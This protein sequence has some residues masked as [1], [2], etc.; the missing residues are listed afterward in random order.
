MK[1]FLTLKILDRFQF[2]FKKLKVDYPTLR[3]IL[4]IKFIMDSRRVPVSVGRTKKQADKDFFHIS[5]LIYAFMGFFTMVPLAIVLNNK[6]ALMT[7]IFGLIMF[8]LLM[9]V[10]ADFSSVLLDVRDKSII[11]TKPVNP[12]VLTV[13]KFIHVFRYLFLVTISLV[14]PVMVTLLIKYTYLEGILYALLFVLLFIFEVVLLNLFI[15]VFTTLLYLFILRFFSGE[16]LKDIINYIQIFMTLVISIGYQIIGR[17]FEITEIFDIEF[18]SKWY[19]YLLMPF[20]F[21]GPFELFFEANY[22]ISI[23][24]YTILIIIIP[25]T[26]F[27]IYTKSLGTF[28]NSLLKLNQG[29][30]QK[31]YKE[32]RKF[33]TNII[34]KTPE[35][36]NF[37][38]FS[39]QMLKSERDFKLRVYP[40]LGL[41]MVFPFLFMFQSGFDLTKLA[42]SK[43]YLN[44]YFCAFMMPM[45]TYMLRYSKNYKAAWVF[46]STPISDFSV[47]KKAALKAFL[48]RLLI[49]IYLVESVIFTCIFGIRIIPDLVAI[50]FT[51]LIFTI[52]CYRVFGNFIPFSQPVE[53]ANKGQTVVFFIITAI[54]GL[55]VGI[56]YAVTLFPILIY[57]YNFILL[58]ITILAWKKGLNGKV[59]INGHHRYN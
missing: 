53:N 45:V 9:T 2:I 8:L 55:M 49:P 22:D 20:W 16:K 12:K 26:A 30:K 32:K 1:D 33:I 59:N 44:L 58:I 50:F 31:P 13:A 25:I 47:F 29:D 43:Q 56:H 15:I 27:I 34:N 37:Y 40:S 28:E 24:I 19:H 54:L 23:I 35:E 36:R 5:L 3:K 7:F 46:Y 38:R 4:Q 17:A 10:I 41:S 6:M 18:T 48:M 11:L 14:G 52:I 42:D 21:G 39:Y 51:I 57:P